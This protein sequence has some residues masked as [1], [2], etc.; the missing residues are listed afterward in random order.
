MLSRSLALS[1]SL[2]YR[3]RLAHPRKL[4]KTNTKLSP[5]C[6]QR[7]QEKNRRQ[8]PF[9]HGIGSV[10]PNGNVTCQHH[11]GHLP[12]LLHTVLLL[13][14]SCTLPSSL[15]SERSKDWF[16]GIF[17]IS[18]LKKSWGVESEVNISRQNREGRVT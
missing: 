16:P 8:P 11:L 5:Q 7:D 18:R 10:L 2:S 12:T 1:L 13:K 4:L 6:N 17:S 15:I 3:E 14:G 9:P